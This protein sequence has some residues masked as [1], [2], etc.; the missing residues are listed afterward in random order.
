[1]LI[2]KH[3]LSLAV[4]AVATSFGISVANADVKITVGQM[5]F[6]PAS[7]TSTSH[8]NDTVSGAINFTTDSGTFNSGSKPFFGFPWVADVDKT[9]TYDTMAGGTQNFTWS[10]VNKT[11]WT[12]SDFVTCRTG[13]NIDNCT[14]VSG[15]LFSSNTQSYSFSLTSEFQYAA[16]LFFDW[17]VNSDIPV[18]AV[19]DC[20]PG[21]DGAV[22][23]PIDSDSDGTP[24]NDMLTNPF[25]GQTAAFIGTLSGVGAGAAGTTVSTPTI[26]GDAGATFNAGSTV[27][28]TGN[29][30]VTLSQVISAGID[31]DND[32]QEMCVGGC[33]DFS[34]TGLSG[35]S[36]SVVLPLSKPIPA[37]SVYRKWI[38]NEWVDFKTNLNN[39]V[40]SA[41][42]SPG[43][44]PLGGYQSGLTQG[45]YCVRLTIVDGGPNDADGVQNGTVVDPGGV[46]ESLVPE[47]D[48]SLG[49]G[50]GGGCTLSDSTSPLGLE[51][52]ALLASLA[53]FGYLRIR[54]QH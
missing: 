26:V 39:T 11:Y 35:N 51:W 15:T 30:K 2:P 33:F 49:S 4:L 50:F 29:G 42:G 9:Y 40:S 6:Y 31:M 7:S 13:A 17:S 16:G 52:L 23:V 37:A 21:G 44:C 3:K 10:W 8:V 28:P 1:M 54:N 25:P 36:I 19:F 12:G 20:D 18:I 48:T 27:D 5:D 34:V 43:N 45:H 41:A 22:C 47:A 14:G 24:G 53:G 38:N 32:A 46:S